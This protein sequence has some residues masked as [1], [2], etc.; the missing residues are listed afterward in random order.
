MSQTQSFCLQEFIAHAKKRNIYREEENLCC[1][2]YYDY[3]C[4]LYYI[5]L[6]I[7]TTKL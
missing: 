3:S 4:C 1:H 6:T 5:T 2:P 7:E